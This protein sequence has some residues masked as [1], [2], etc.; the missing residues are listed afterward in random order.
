MPDERG[1]VGIVFAI[2]LVPIAG[3]IGGAVEYSRLNGLRA[4]AQAAADAAVLAVGAQPNASDSAKIA[5][6]TNMQAAAFGARPNVTLN[7][8]QVTTLTAG[9]KWQVTVSGS[10]PTSFAKLV[11]VQS[12]NFSATAQAIIGSGVSATAPLEM[13]IALDNTGSMS[14]NMADLKTAASNLVKAVLN[15]G[16][17]APRVSIVPYVATVN[18]GLTDA[19]S[20][21]NYIDTKSVGPWNGSWFDSSWEYTQAGCTPSGG[22]GGGGGSGGAGGGGSGDARDILEILN[23][24]RRM[25]QEL[26][27]ITAAHADVTPATSPYT[28]STWTSP[29]TGKTYTIPVGW[30][31]VRASEGNGCDQLA[32]PPLVSDYDLFHR[33]LNPNTGLP[34]QWKGCVIAREG[35]EEQAWRN[36][37]WGTSEPAKTDYDVTD[38]PPSTSDDL[39]LF[40]PYFWPNEL[41]ISPFTWNPVAPGPYSPATQGFHNNYMVGKQIP[42][43]W[44]WAMPPD[45]W[46]IGE[47][48]F[49]YDG[50]KAAIIQETPDASGYTYGP[51]A[52]CP[53]AVL[54]LT[55]DQTAALNKINGLTYW[56]SGGT[57][58]SE[59]LMW[60]WRTLSPNAPY[61][62]G[63]AYGTAGVDK[64]IVLMTDGVNELIDNGNNATSLNTNNISDYSAYGYLGNN[65]MYD[66]LPNPNTGGNGLHNYTDVAAFFDS[67]L[68]KACTNAKAAGVTIYTVVYNHAGFLTSAQQSTAQKIMQQCASATTKSYLAT[69]AATLNAAFTTIGS[70]VG[71][72]TG[73]RLVR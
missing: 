67:R 64:V 15:G 27:G 2:A 1:A 46:E 44:G 53:D 71:G 29:D 33:I 56:Q 61:K 32:R 11:G 5:A 70:S 73:L 62:D 18:P 6:A 38:T 52:G 54:R 21:A 14:A 25:A 50:S 30:V 4:Q 28:T 63:K 47:S 40:V 72:A 37:N 39:S 42:S 3:A 31:P 55:N 26:F 24:I 35:K 22:G 43:T 19:T 12:L 49:T 34:V 66:A 10:A 51:N 65:R 9:S 41:S 16:G 17:G 59:G 48:L 69:D 36:A 68:L 57:I 60:A 23:P 45:D 58:I 20:V 8:P 13:A 7:A